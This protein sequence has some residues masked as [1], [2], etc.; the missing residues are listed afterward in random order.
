MQ[1]VALAAIAMV[2]EVDGEGDDLGADLPGARLVPADIEGLLADAVEGP[3]SRVVQK[4]VDSARSGVDPVIEAD[5]K[6]A[7]SVFLFAQTIRIPRVKEWVESEAHW[8]YANDKDQLWQMLRNLTS[9]D[10]NPNRI[11]DTRPMGMPEHELFPER[12][13]LRWMMSM[14]VDVAKVNLATNPELLVGDEPCLMKESRDR[15]CDM[16]VMA[17]AKDVLI[18]LSRPKD[19]PG[20]FTELDDPEHVEALNVQAYRKARRFIAGPS[21][22]CLNHIRAV[23]KID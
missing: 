2:R 3:A 4:I 23:S 21:K 18:Q 22:E 8:E 7:L 17:I 9:S 12:T 15:P 1:D 10:W 13:L 14:N 16:V 11:D 19:S 5:E 6:L 20:G